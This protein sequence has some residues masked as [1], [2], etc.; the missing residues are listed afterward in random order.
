MIERKVFVY[1]DAQDVEDLRLQIYRKAYKRGYVCGFAIG[2][3]VCGILGLCI[4]L[5]ALW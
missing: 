2:L 1:L 3:A 4:F 5:A